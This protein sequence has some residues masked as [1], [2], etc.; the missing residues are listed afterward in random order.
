[1]RLSHGRAHFDSEFACSP[2]DP[3][4]RVQEAI[5]MPYYVRQLTMIRFRAL[6]NNGLDAVAGLAGGER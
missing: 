3:L 4:W 6:G 5:P 1:M 2:L